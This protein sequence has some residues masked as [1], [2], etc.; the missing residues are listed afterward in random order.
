MIPII[1]CWKNNRRTNT[2]K[3]TATPTAL[4]IK[5][6]SRPPPPPH[7]HLEESNFWRCPD[8]AKVSILNE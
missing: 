1:K 6:P 2:R 7:N 8:S 4:K 3:E 5:L